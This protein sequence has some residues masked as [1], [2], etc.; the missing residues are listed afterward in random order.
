M[1]VGFKG[2]TLVVAAIVV[3]AAVGL[4]FLGRENYLLFHSLAEL[5]SIVVG[6]VLFAVAARMYGSAGNAMLM[7]LGIGFFWA[8]MID[9]VHML[10][11]KGMGVF[12]EGG[13]NLPTQL[14]V[15]A[16]Y[17]QSAVVL[18]AM[19]GLHWR[20][21]SPWPAFVAVGAVTALG[22][23]A[24]FGGLFPT[25]YIEGSGLTAFKVISEHVISVLWIAALVVLVRN[26]KDLDD[27][28]TRWLAAAMILTIGSELA[29]TFYVSVFGLSNLIGHLFKLAAY[30]AVF[31]VVQRDM[32]TR[33]MKVMKRFAPLC[34][35]CK[36]VRDED[37]S[38][39]TVEQYLDREFSR[40]VSHGI[41]PACM[42]DLYPGYK[43]DPE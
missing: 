12:A 36:A 21:R 15:L 17:L 43:D 39:V 5:G 3:G 35:R 31:L 4:Y 9:M 19:L 2:P 41:C 37:G 23:G 20:M 11:Y 26:R 42:D 32:F 22:L 40:P 16:R 29:F 18:V 30:L 27:W 6:V 1:R 7:L 8:G 10:A 24:I 33:P 25:A 34:A 14:W 13:A 28:T 38:W